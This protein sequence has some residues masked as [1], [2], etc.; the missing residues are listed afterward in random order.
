VAAAALIAQL[1]G[2]ATVPAVPEHLGGPAADAKADNAK[3]RPSAA[4]DAK[5]FA[6]AVERGDAAWQ[7]QD[8]D[9]AIYYYVLAM[10][11]S[12]RDA[13][14]LA[15]IGAIE[16]AR[17]NA[18]LAEKAFE[19]AHSAD[20]QEP[21]I[22][23]RLARLYLHDGK[24]E[25]AADVYA[26]VLARDPRRSRALDGMGEVCLARLDFGRSI[27]YFDQ[28]LQGDRPDTATV[29]TDRGYAKLRINDLTGAEADFRAALAVAP[30]D[31]A[32]R[33]LGDLQVRHGDT[34]AALESLL[35][36]MDTGQAYNEI[37]VVLMS[38]SNYQSAREYFTKSIRASA[39]WFDE[40]QKNLAVADEHLANTAP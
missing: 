1:C 2:C 16:D 3:S 8:F 34:A 33:Y 12:P 10:D 17:G 19:M 32:W 4:H 18:A 21:R 20:P 26:Q 37:G 9:R 11:K 14:T 6:E 40:A 13:P 35:N 22:A 7:A 29:L 36:V 23:E 27:P 28:A 39:A 5:S 15:K 24:V 31:D 30:R 38:A 25:S